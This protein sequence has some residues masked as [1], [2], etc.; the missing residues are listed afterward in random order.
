MKDKYWEKISHYIGLLP[1]GALFGLVAFVANIEIKD[2]DLW[3]HLGV[4]KFIWQNHIVPNV[5]ILSCSFAGNPWI[6]HEWLFQVIVYVIFDTWGA[7]GLLKMQITIVC[8]TMGILLLLGYSK[9]KQLFITFMLFLVFLV[10]QQR[11]T[12]RPDI[13][14]LF[15]FAIYIFILA[16]YIDKR[17]ASWAILIIQVLWVNVHGFFFLGPLFVLIG[18]VSEWIKR[19]IPLPYEWN[20]VGRLNDEEFK[21]LQFIFLLVILACLVNPYFIQGAWYPLG[22]LFSLSGENKIFFD[23]IQELQKPV[24]SENLFNLRHFIYYKLLIVLSFVSFI[25]NRRKIDIS[26]M[27]FWVIFLLFSLQAIR[28]AIFFAFAAYLVIMTNVLSIRL[29]DIVPLRFTAKKFQHI[30][31]IVFK[32]LLL[33]FLFQFGHDISALSYYDFEKFKLKS[34]Y[35]GV[36]Q[37]N[38]PDKA[39]QFLIDNKVKGNFFNDFNSGAYLVGK[40][41][42][43]IKAYIDGRTEVYGGEF[44]KKYQK[45]WLEGDGKLFEKEVDKF[46][47]TGVLLN[48]SRQRLPE[49]FLSYLYES[50]DWIIVY[51]DYDGTVFLKDGEHNRDLIKKH[52]IDLS[53]WEAK[54]SDLIKIGAARLVPYRNFFRAHALYTLKLYEPAL[55][56]LDEAI[57][58]SPSYGVAYHLKGQIFIKQER[59]EEA[60]KNV[61]YAALLFPAHQQIRLDLAYCYFELDALKEALDQTKALIQTW[62]HDINAHALLVEIYITTDDYKNALSAAQNY[63]VLDPKVSDDFITLGDLAFD[64]QAYELAKE[65]YSLALTIDHRLDRT[66]SQL[67][68]VYDLLGDQQ[69]AKNYSQKAET[70][71]S[72]NETQ[73][74]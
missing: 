16:L 25:F 52:K 71:L 27:I 50:K 59:Y 21:R 23:V 5:D 29:E 49:K 47:I 65:I 46:N 15:F 33:V 62:P 42:P 2:L 22:V 54:R 28:N 67:S 39:V 40:V 36:S 3:L 66:Y 64:R 30:T 72:S 31:S 13:F 44:F 26:A 34:E 60:Y 57:T 12:V 35:G 58:L 53:Q 14:S 37:R 1:I 32:I 11:F 9:P 43:D 73:E 41:Y 61:R 74:D 6:N 20:D 51:F 24:T 19:R 38:Y 48:S 7:N 10:F 63:K 4:G 55:S 69:S 68:R 17:W 8:V 18:L 45:I 56:E 70:Y